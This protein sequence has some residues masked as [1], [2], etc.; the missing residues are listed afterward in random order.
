M[1]AADIE[2]IYD[3]LA[4]QPLLLRAIYQI[5]EQ[6]TMW[7]RGYI[8][9]LYRDRVFELAYEERGRQLRELGEWIGLSE[10]EIAVL[11]ENDL[12]LMD[13]LNN[14]LQDERDPAA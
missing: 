13:E 7:A 2:A 9:D 11:C 6:T 1:S 8:A 3:H 14:D 12:D 10:D 5:D 4:S